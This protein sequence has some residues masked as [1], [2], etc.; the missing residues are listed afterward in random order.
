MRLGVQD[1]ISRVSQS[2]MHPQSTTRI[3]GCPLALYY[4][5]PDKLGDK[6]GALCAL[7]I[8][9]PWRSRPRTQPREPVVQHLASTLS[10]EPSPAVSVVSDSGGWVSCD[11]GKLDERGMSMRDDSIEI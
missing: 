8:Q 1:M 10:G 3:T 6:S 9:T 11:A 7:R 5:L 4:R 2:E